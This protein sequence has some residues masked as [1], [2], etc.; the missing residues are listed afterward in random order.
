MNEMNTDLIQACSNSK[1]NI[2][3]I[4]DLIDN[5]AD[6]NAKSANDFTALML[7]TLNDRLDIVML[8]Y[9]AGANVETMRAENN[10]LFLAVALECNDEIVDFLYD[11][12]PPDHHT[13]PT[14]HTLLVE[15]VSYRNLSIIEW[16]VKEKKY[17]PGQQMSDGLSAFYIACS[18]TAQGRTLD[19]EII[20]IL[21]ES[22][23]PINVLK[24][25]KLT[26]ETGDKTFYVSHMYLLMSL[27]KMILQKD[28]TKMPN[29][30]AFF[31][32]SKK[33]KRYFNKLVNNLEQLE[34]KKTQISMLGNLIDVIDDIIKELSC[35]SN[36]DLIPR[37]ADIVI[38]LQMLEIKLLILEL[39]LSPRKLTTSLLFETSQDCLEIAFSMKNEK[40]FNQ[41]I[42]NIQKIKKVLSTYEPNFLVEFD[43]LL[44]VADA[45][46]VLLSGEKNY[47]RTYKKFMEL[48]NIHKSKKYIKLYSLLCRCLGKIFRDANQPWASA[49]YYVIAIGYEDRH[50]QVK[51]NSF[52]YEW[53][54]KLVDRSQ[55]QQ[56][57]AKI[58]QKIVL[59]LTQIFYPIEESHIKL[60][61]TQH[62]V[63]LNL[64]SYPELQELAGLLSKRSETYSY[65]QKNSVLRLSKISD[66]DQLKK[67][68]K[69]A[70]EQ[71]KIESFRSN[72]I[73]FIREYFAYQ[74][75]KI[76]KQFDDIQQQTE[77]LVS[78][79][80]QLSNS[81]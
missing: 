54:N 22:D 24:L 49:N 79:A 61:I 4:I 50:S 75:Q 78:E 28:Y 25:F 44:K 21:L 16:L 39:K 32:D 77:S 71:Y 31:A 2:E 73:N 35:F 65:N 47:D 34:D 19:H 66:V 18:N 69:D 68:V 9:Y 14:G 48:K 43:F 38:E 29:L 57:L 67:D 63:I 45:A 55:L 23:K 8:L 40:L 56:N 37:L 52:H 5:G 6:V 62:S 74:C 20:F 12:T 60:T 36:A 13:K 80:S 70:H 27:Y 15:A 3:T 26:E 33:H 53:L 58:K 76:E 46:K 64:T 17:N 11:V 41:S 1:I 7:A 10:A 59:Q 51:S 42:D 81:N 72:K 30:H